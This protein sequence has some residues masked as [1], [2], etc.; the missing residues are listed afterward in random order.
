ML[1]RP[2]TGSAELKEA[3]NAR[4]DSEVGTKPEH[5]FSEKEVVDLEM[6]PSVNWRRRADSNRCIE[7][8]V[9]KRR[10]DTE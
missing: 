3:I 6:I 9:L 5:F 4:F 10:S 7:A 2:A 8:K 1:G